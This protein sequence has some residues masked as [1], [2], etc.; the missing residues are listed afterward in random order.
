M[1]NRPYCPLALS[2]LCAS[3]IAFNATPA[4]AQKIAVPLPL[5]NPVELPVSV[6]SRTKP[7]ILKRMK[8]VV[9]NITLKDKDGQDALTVLLDSVEN[10]KDANRKPLTIGYDFDAAFYQSQYAAIAIDLPPRTI[11]LKL[12]N[13]SLPRALDS[14]TQAL[15]IG[16]FADEE[17]GTILIHLIKLRGTV[18]LSDQWRNLG[19][20][21]ATGQQLV[22]GAKK[23][24]PF[25][26]ARASLDGAAVTE[27][28]AIKDV[29]KQAKVAYIIEDDLP[30][31][32]Y[33]FDFHELPIAAALDTICRKA[34]VGW[35]KDIVSETFVI[36]IGKNYPKPADSVTTETTGKP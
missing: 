3:V 2:A 31:A 11:T 14:I 15:G 7:E 22:S 1:K 32:K 8:G 4:L 6:A 24:I 16:W 34:G 5:A 30:G 18:T 33:S 36:R 12:I 27:A 10:S 9:I 26:D 35:K 25:G 19:I 13:A 29:L 28:D 21:P 23:D 20:D 17:N